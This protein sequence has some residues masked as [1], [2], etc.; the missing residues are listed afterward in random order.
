MTRTS[1]V[2]DP[3][4]G[5]AA[6]V[7][8]LRAL[9]FGAIVAQLATLASFTPSRE[10]AEA[11]IPMADPTLASLLQDQTDE[12]VRLLDEQAQASI[13]AARDIRPALD[14]AERGGQLTAA[15]LLE[16]AQTLDATARFAARLRDWRLPQ[17]AG[18]RDELDPA[19]ELAERIGRTVDEAGEILDSASPE[20]G[21]IRKRMRTAQDRVRERLNAMLRSSQ[22]AGVIGEAI[23][24]V[25]AGRGQG[26]VEGDR[27]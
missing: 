21:A 5:A 9:E 26:P 18:V 1:P 12:A 17:L 4:S 2:A 15:D 16:I 24:T 7:G 22:M 27:S 10:L 3:A 11:T 23:V 14:R 20:L 19:P 6:D 13:G 25:R 8:T